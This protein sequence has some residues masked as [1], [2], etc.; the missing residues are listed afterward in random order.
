MPEGM[1]E[2]AD[3]PLAM[4]ADA[5]ADAG[6]PRDSAVPPAETPLAERAPG[7]VWGMPD[8]ALP[9]AAA[10]KSQLAAVEAAPPAGS[11]AGV[12][13][14]PGASASIEPGLAGRAPGAVWGTP[15][16]ART[17]AVP[18]ARVAAIDLGPRVAGRAPGLV[19]GMPDM[20]PAADGPPAAT[21][22][23]RV[24]KPVPLPGPGNPAAG[25]AA[26]VVAGQA[27]TPARTTGRSRQPAP[28]MPAPAKPAPPAPAVTLLAK[29]A[30]AAVVARAE[31]TAAAN[32]PAAAKRAHALPPAPAKP[33]ADGNA[34]ATE[35]A[36]VAL[37][38]RP[39]PPPPARPVAGGGIEITDGLVA[40]DVAPSRSGGA[41]LG[42]I[43]FRPESA[44]LT[45]DAVV[46][47]AEFLNGA[48]APAA[49]IRI[50][51][52]AAA[53][54]LALDRARAVGLALVQGGVPADRLELTLAHGGSG[55]QARLFL[56]A[57]EL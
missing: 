54:A 2:P 7:V 44:M 9:P 19:W 31:R 8:M 53:P 20:A 28:P 50:V 5:V 52:E 55:D 57:P 12:S 33:S 29:A 30:P 16:R 25:P 14:E 40:I 18:P 24:E 21:P 17:R 39:A 11:M 43:P 27:D 32:A 15:D 42:S 6:V 4:L 13:R 48:E 41:A 47:L 56:A 35:P 26:I 34:T 38:D 51:G 37:A 36:A 49:R 23:T 3:G 45:P 46:L 1:A 22:A 10:P